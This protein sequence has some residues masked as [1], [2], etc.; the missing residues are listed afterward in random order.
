MVTRRLA[1]PRLAASTLWEPSPL[2]N[3]LDIV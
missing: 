2:Q 1:K 3:R